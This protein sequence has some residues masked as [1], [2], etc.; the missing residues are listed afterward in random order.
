MQLDCYREKISRNEQVELYF[1]VTGGKIKAVDCRDVYI[2]LLLLANSE[3]GRPQIPVAMQ[4]SNCHDTPAYTSFLQRWWSCINS[5]KDVEL[6]SA[7][8]VDKNWPSIHACS[9]VFC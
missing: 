4:L 2:M 1:D 7:V 5:E 3:S 9:W 8:V 6:P